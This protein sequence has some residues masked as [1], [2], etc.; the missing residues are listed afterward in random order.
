MR[1]NKCGFCGSMGK[2]GLC[3]RC[4]RDA[5]DLDKV[6]GKRARAKYDAPVDDEY[7]LVKEIDYLGLWCGDERS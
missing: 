6:L 5:D 2:S 1:C 3:I 4:L 7:K